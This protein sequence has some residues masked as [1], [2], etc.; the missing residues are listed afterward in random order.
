MSRVCHGLEYIKTIDS[1]ELS[2]RHDLEHPRLGARAGGRILTGLK[3]M[4]T[5]LTLLCCW[6]ALVQPGTGYGTGTTL[7]S[8]NVYAVWYNGTG[9]TGTASEIR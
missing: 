1:I 8:P 5:G 7:R 6:D 4:C 3:Q 9:C 2:R